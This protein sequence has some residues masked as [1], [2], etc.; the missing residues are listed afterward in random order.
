[1]SIGRAL[2]K[3]LLLAAESVRVVRGGE[4]DNPLRLRHASDKHQV[5][6]PM[7]LQA[8]HFLFGCPKPLLALLAVKKCVLILVG[9]DDT[10]MFLLFG[11]TFLTGPT[12][13]E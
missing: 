12:R 6:N 8:P 2:I 9:V 11:E 7:L 4:W 5:V 13:N 3:C 10:S 1:M